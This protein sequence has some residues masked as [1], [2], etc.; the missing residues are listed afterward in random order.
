MYIGAALFHGYVSSDGYFM[1]M[2]TFG[3]GNILQNTV[4]YHAK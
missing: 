1:D 4:I 2:I 3:T